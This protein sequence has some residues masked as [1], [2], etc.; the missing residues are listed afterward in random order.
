MAVATVSVSKEKMQQG[1]EM[2]LMNA[3]RY[4]QDVKLLYMLGSFQANLP[5][6]H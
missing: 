2:I 5:P 6:W 3:L 4:V 1:I